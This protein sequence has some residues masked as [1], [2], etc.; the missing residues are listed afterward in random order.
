MAT[1]IVLVWYFMFGL[2]DPSVIG[3]FAD[4]AQCDQV[5]AQ[6]DR[7]VVSAFL[8]SCW[9]APLETGRKPAK[10]GG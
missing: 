8:T 2:S 6:I 3:P 1:H 10:D 9:S 5:R 4:K 7:E